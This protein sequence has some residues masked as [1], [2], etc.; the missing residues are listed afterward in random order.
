MTDLTRL[1]AAA[2]AERIASGEVSAVQVAEAH[3]ARIDAVDE[4]VHAFLHVD[5]EGALAQARAVDAKR[6]AGEELGPLAGVPL[7]L[8][9]IFTTVGVPTTV[10]SKILEGWIPPYDATL[11]R[12]LKEAGVVILGKTNMDEFA[13]GSSTEN[14]AY[15]PTGNPW[16]LTRIPGGS[17]G[18]SSAALASFQAPLAIGTDT[19]GS[20]R[21]PA[22]VTGTVG[23][24]PTYGAVSRYGMVAFS[25]SL[26]QGGPCART[27]LD[28][29]LLHEVIAGHDPLDSTSID[30]PVPPVVAAARAG[31][32][33]GMR[34]GVVKEFAGEGY[35]AGVMQRFTESV[36][37]LRELGA[38]IVEVSCPSFE[39][40]LAAYYLIAPSE[41]SSNLARFD[42]LRYGLRAGDDG[43]RSAEE[44]TA[45]TREAGFGPEVKRR[46]ILGTYALS[47]GYYDAYYGSAQKVR[48]LITQDFQRAFGDVDVL[49][50]P[51]TPTTAFPIGERADDP[52]AMYL[53]DL[54][55]IPSN[56]AGNAAMSLPC[57]LAPEDGLPV[58]LQI[59]APAMAD[60]RLYRVGA[61]VEAAFTARWGHPLLEEAPT[62]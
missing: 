30:A 38:E 61:A 52:M 41:C 1:T 28:T 43:T 8:K 40:A 19:G 51:T 37:L 22:A 62:L 55:T 26:D 4:K 17:G 14:S 60:D 57:G 15:G 34:I 58:G 9:D 21:Q 5:R 25:S 48:T 35:Q 27:V 53:A 12:R 23:V 13:M 18:G 45:L 24:K 11:T 32:V 54:C 36:E 16:D 10:G 7:A 59:I 46:V 49:V 39:Y 33:K 50:S 56:L 20:I 47:S 2:T 3:L 31:D 29:A 6:A 44:V 42:G